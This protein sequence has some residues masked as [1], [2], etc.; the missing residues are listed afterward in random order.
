MRDMAKGPCQVEG[1]WGPRNPGSV[2]CLRHVEHRE[3]PPVKLECE[4][5]VPQP[6]ALTIYGAGAAYCT[7]CGS[8]MPGTVS[9]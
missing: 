6:E 9:A 8:P 7:W 2:W 1:C 3:A 5:V 4:C